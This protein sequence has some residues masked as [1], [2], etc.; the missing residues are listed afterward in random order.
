MQICEQ[1]QLHV[2][3]QR[4]MVALVMGQLLQHLLIDLLWP[5]ALLLLL[6]LVLLCRE[7]FPT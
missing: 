3:P 1:Q 4:E 6:M 5:R 2:H 7:N